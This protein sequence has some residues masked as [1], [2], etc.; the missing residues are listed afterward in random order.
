MLSLS[1]KLSLAFLAV[2]LFGI[3]L[4][5]ALAGW[6]TVNEFGNFAAAQ[7]QN[8]MLNRLIDLYES[9]GNW[10]NVN[11]ILARPSRLAPAGQQPPPV[12]LVRGFLLLNVD[13]TL[14]WPV[15]RR[16]TAQ[17]RLRA[18]PLTSNGQ[19]IG[20]YV[21][22]RNPPDLSP[23]RLEYE[24][25]MR[26]SL[27]VAA[28]AAALFSMLLGVVLAR[29]LTRPVQELTRATQA[30]AQ[31]D[32][33]QQVPVRSQDELGQLAASFNRMNAELARS[34]ALRRQMT[35]DIAHDLRTPLSVI[36]GHAEALSD[37][38]LPATPDTIYIIYDEA[39][40][41]QRLVEDLRILSLADAGELRLDRA[42]TSPDSLVERAVIAHSARAD[43]KHV[44]LIS[45][46]APA[47][48]QILADAD[49]M[50][51]V[52]D[53]LLTNALH[54]TPVGGRITLSAQ[55]SGDWVRIAVADS[56]LGIAEAELDQL[57]ERFYRGDKSR[58][59]ADENGTGLGLAIARSIVEGHH[60][61]IWAASPPGQGATF[62][63][64]LPVV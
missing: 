18:L 15:D 46:I 55:R 13:R 37:G 39:R 11:Q 38:V 40:R 16:V 23:L 41:L 7:N 54:H 20:Y 31:G 50:A 1:A 49:R 34:Q 19:V 36:L 53:N 4:V 61:R 64:E 9:Q 30:V 24:G 63:L 58:H 22:P 25:R 2:S 8:Q 57:F 29:T 59:R 3:I 5:A 10:A 33:T 42:P 44:Q 51:Q 17:D 6:V 32:L 56:G 62:Y 21:I 48:P 45:H 28:L 26:N 52:L 47:L 27:M 35:A 12:E 14:I 60:G 43:Q